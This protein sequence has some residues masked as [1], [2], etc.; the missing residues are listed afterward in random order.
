MPEHDVYAPP[1]EGTAAPITGA[2][3]DDLAAYDRDPSV[4]TPKLPRTAAG[5]ALF[6][7]AMALMAGWQTLDMV[8]LRG[9]YV[10]FPWLILAF[11]ASS[12][13]GAVALFRMRGWAALAT[14]LSTGVLALVSGLWL[15]LAVAHGF[16][17][18]YSVFTPA[19]AAVSAILAAM[20][21]GPLGRAARLRKH[22]AGEG[23]HLG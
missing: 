12:L 7:S 22:F 18:L 20:S 8:R 3:R 9:A 15:L 23:M 21:I 14:L 13:V 16:I 19:S 2:A 6:T 17:A 11:G 1:R 4:M 10:A 5:A